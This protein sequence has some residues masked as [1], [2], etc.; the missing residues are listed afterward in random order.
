MKKTNMSEI[1]IPNWLVKLP[2]GD[3]CIPEICEMFN[4]TYHCVYQRLYALNIPSY[5]KEVNLGMGVNRVMIMYTWNGFEEESKKINK[6]RLIKL[7]TGVKERLK[8]EK[9]F[10]NSK[11]E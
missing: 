5:K 10:L 6:L 1:N 11:K 9:N 7:K 8:K 4:L 3:Y 2:A